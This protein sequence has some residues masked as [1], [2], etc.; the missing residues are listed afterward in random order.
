MTNEGFSKAV[1][2]G[3]AEETTHSAVQDAYSY[4]AFADRT[5]LYKLRWRLE[6]IAFKF[7]YPAEYQAIAFLVNA[8]RKTREAYIRTFIQSVDTL[9]TELNFKYSIEGRLKHFYSIFNKMITRNKPFEEIYDLYAVR[10]I[11]QTE[12]PRECFRAY[13]ILSHSYRPLPERFKNYISSPKN[14]GYQS[15]HATVVGPE[16]KNVEVQIRTLPMQKIAEDGIAAHWI[17]KWSRTS[18]FQ[19]MENRITWMS[20]ILSDGHTMKQTIKPHQ[21]VMNQNKIAALTTEERQ[22]FHREMT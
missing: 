22:G 4:S 19:K 2:H 15:I 17:Y 11:L 3:F 9:F 20:R 5:G 18:R 10:I 14:N 12:N 16:G 8:S 7:L 13:D 6:D 1:N 21:A